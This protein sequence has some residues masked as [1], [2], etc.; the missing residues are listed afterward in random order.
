[1]PARVSQDGERNARHGWQATKDNQFRRGAREAEGA[2]LLREY[3]VKSLI[4]GSNP[5]LSARQERG[6][7]PRFL[8]AR[9]QLSID[10]FASTRNNWQFIALTK[11]GSANATVSCARSSAG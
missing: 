10:A 1:M 7:W 8:F 9:D 4:E 2:P 11:D 6:R 3:R 5:S